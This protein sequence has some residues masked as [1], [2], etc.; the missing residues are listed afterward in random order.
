VSVQPAIRESTAK[1]RLFGRRV[2][3]SK[4]RS[5]KQRRRGS[6]VVNK[7]PTLE[8]TRVIVANEF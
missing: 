3:A 8:K 1:A 7:S 4:S 2:P 5:G 6:R